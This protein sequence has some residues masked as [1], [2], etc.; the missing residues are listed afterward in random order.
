MHVLTRIKVVLSFV[1]LLSYYSMREASAQALQNPRIIARLYSSRHVVGPRVGKDVSLL[2]C[3]S[4]VE[5][6]D[7]S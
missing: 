4:L 5:Y 2:K 7:C 6:V 3:T 1:P